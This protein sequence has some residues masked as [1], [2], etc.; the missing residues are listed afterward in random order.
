MAKGYDLIVL[1]GGTGGYVAAIRASQLGMKV[2][3]VERDKL[4]GT[5]LHRGCIPTK[6]LLRSASLVHWMREGES[7]G[8]YPGEVTFN[9]RK[10][11]E[12]KEE[13]VNRLY[14]GVIHL[15]KKNKIDVFAGKGSIQSTHPISLV[16][17]KDITEHELIT[18]QYLLI[19]TGA[20]PRALSNLSIDGHFILSSD[21]MLSLDQLPQSLLIV[22]GGVIGVE[23][24]SLLSDLG[25]QVTIVEVA[26]RILPGED[27]DISHEMARQL[28]KRGVTIFTEAEVLPDFFPK[29][30][31]T[32]VKIRNINGEIIELPVQKI[33]LSVGRMGNGD[34][35][36]LEKTG[37]ELAQGFIQVNQWY[38]TKE[39]NI[40]A[41]GD[42]IGGMQLAHV[43]AREGRIAVEHM[44]GL[45]P[46]PLDY[47]MIPRCVYGRP[48]VTSV[49]MTEKEAKD[50]GYRIEVGKVPFL[51]IGKSLINGDSSGFCKIIEDAQTR[52]LLGIHL[53]G[54]GVTELIGE[55]VL[56]RM[57]DATAGELANIVHPH[58]SLSEIFGETALDVHRLAI[59]Y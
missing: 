33:L 9:F 16:V 45:Q 5:C 2:A 53:I 21:H 27:L 26:D 41:I 56:A 30:S 1:G 17:E 50:R 42:V 35:I 29:N 19:A 11:Q 24:A 18:G 40:Y 39:K 51:S 58:P 48:E 6:A 38:E 54:S 28:R 25:V 43:A 49:G 7:F 52:D 47:T 3:I 10:M 57:L 20:R 23:W 12:K 13:I 36:G 44:A 22:G 34:G 4:G 46:S 55:G 14:R 59:H 37:V 8:V 31:R 15:V 32:I